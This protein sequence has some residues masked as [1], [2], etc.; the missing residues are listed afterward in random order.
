MYSKKAEKKLAAYLKQIGVLLA[1]GQK[2]SDELAL[3]EKRLVN[4]YE[5]LAKAMNAAAEKAAKKYDGGLSTEAYDDIL[6][7]TEASYSRIDFE[8]G[9]PLDWETALKNFKKMRAYVGKL[10]KLEKKD[11]AAL[12]KYREEERKAKRLNRAAKKLERPEEPEAQPAAQPAA[13]VTDG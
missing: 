3:M 6:S 4:L 12:Q 1:K 9:L 10:M 8:D 11:I 7:L 2:M 13:P 5:R